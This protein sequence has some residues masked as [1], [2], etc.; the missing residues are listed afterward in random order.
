MKLRNRIVLIDDHNV[1][2]ELVRFQLGRSE[3]DRYEIV[4]EGSTGQEAVDVCLR[5]YPDML[6]LDLM[7]PGMNGVEVYRRLKPRL[8]HLKVLYFSASMKT[9]LITE[10]LELG[11]A[12]FV[13]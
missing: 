12:G 6:L 4:G 1:M 9:P 13:G 11:A 5:T 3:P 8:P 2:R 7:L 10:G